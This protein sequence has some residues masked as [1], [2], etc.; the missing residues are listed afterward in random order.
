MNDVRRR[1]RVRALAIEATE[2][3]FVAFVADVWAD[4]VKLREDD[5][6]SRRL[7]HAIRYHRAAL[8]E[9]ERLEIERE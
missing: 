5:L 7:A 9:I 3:A 1:E 2:R 6:F 8:D 4:Y